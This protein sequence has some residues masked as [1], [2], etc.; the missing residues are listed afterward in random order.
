MRDLDSDFRIDPALESENDSMSGIYVA[1]ALASLGL[2]LV[3]V[4]S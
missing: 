4:F 2:F 1:V 3:V